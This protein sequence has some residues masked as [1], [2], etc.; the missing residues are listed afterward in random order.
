MD[1]TLALKK[2]WQ[3]KEKVDILKS[4]SSF[5]RLIIVHAG[6]KN[7]LVEGA[8]LIFKSRSTTGDYHGQM[9]AENF[10]KWFQEKLLSNIPLNSVIIM[11][12]TQYHSVRINKPP[13]KR[14]TKEGMIEWLLNKGID[15][16]Q[17][18]QKFE[19]IEL[20]NQNKPK[21]TLYKA[22]ETIKLHES[23][24]TTIHVSF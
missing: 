14:S 23:L 4:S 12:N 9:N 17:S 24:K 11:D 18:I 15:C 13:S 21:E 7:E 5:H 22:H 20:I 3:S 6:K 16:S 10:D 2:C 8:V 19:L 1:N